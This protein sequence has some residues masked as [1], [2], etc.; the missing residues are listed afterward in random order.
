[1]IKFGVISDVV[2]V[3]DFLAIA[4]D[5]EP[6]ILWLYAI[7]I[8]IFGVLGCGTLLACECE[9]SLL[10]IAIGIGVVVRGP[11]GD[12]VYHIRWIAK[13]VV[14]VRVRAHAEAG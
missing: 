9:L 11:L 8:L 4:R 3:G 2:I 13:I 14:T 5:D 1:M 7:V 10:N 6:F 12:I